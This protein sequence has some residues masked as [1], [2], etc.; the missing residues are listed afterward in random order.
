MEG[1]FKMKSRYKF[2]TPTV[3][4]AAIGL[5]YLYIVANGY[6][7]YNEGINL[8]YYA[9]ANPERIIE[10]NPYMSVTEI[11][12]EDLKDVPRIKGMLDV[13]LDQEFPLHDDGFAVFDD[14][15]NSY[16]INED[17]GNI[18]VQISMSTSE[19]DKH[20]DWLQENV[21]GF[22]MEYGD[23]YFSFSQWIA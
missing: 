5:F 20:A 10:K 17:N 3:I 19:T 11:T 13:A 4:V 2:L 8:T 14:S 9:E 12:E 22:L 23:R 18:R 21:P 1:L 6:S 16:W 7:P 15:L